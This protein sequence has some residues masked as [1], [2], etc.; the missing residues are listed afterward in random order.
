MVIALLH[1]N[2]QP[3]TERDE[4]VEKGWQKPAVQQKTTEDN[5]SL[6]SVALLLFI[7]SL[8][9][10]NQMSILVKEST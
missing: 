9:P 1:S 3:R 6:N 5:Y 10:Q 7:H 8:M 2:G 4:D